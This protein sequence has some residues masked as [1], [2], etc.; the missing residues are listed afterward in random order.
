ML[1]GDITTAFNRMPDLRALF[2]EDNDFEGT[3]NDNFLRRSQRLIQLDVSDNR[4]KGTLPFHFFVEDEFKQLEVMDWHGNELSGNLPDMLVPNKVLQFLSLYDNV[5]TGTLPPSW[6]THLHGVFHLDLSRNWLTGELPTTIGEMKALLNLF[7]GT[8]EWEPGPIP[9]SWSNLFRL[10]ELSLKESHRIGQI[11]EFIGTLDRLKLLDLDSN[12]FEGQIPTALGNLSNLEFLLLNRNRLIGGIPSELSKLTK[13]RMAFLEGNYLMGN[14]SPLCSLP[15]FVNTENGVWSLV[16]TDC[17]GGGS[18][19]NA[20]TLWPVQCECC[21][22]CCMAAPLLDS[23]DI[24]PSNETGV[25]GDDATPGGSGTNVTQPAV[26]LSPRPSRPT[27]H[28]WTATANLNPRWESVYARESY[29]F[30]EEVWF[31]NDDDDDTDDPVTRRQRQLL[32]ESIY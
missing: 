23:Y 5:F 15:N 7:L 27:C 3:I 25:D 8:N 29:I 11:P 31:E 13:L 26:V 12:Q 19:G 18:T 4:L 17:Q 14:A 1:S 30:G 16:V 21:S 9:S 22:H 24:L 28:D 2:L 10:K 6:G 32:V 20:T